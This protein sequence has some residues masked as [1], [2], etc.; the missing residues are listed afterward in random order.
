[1]AASKS[2][3]SHRMALLMEISYLK[4]FVTVWKDFVTVLLKM[5]DI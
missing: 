3:I 2:N 4:K 1:M 5:L